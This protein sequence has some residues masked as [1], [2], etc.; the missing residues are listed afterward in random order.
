MIGEVKANQSHGVRVVKEFDLRSTIERCT[1]S[2]PV[3][4]IRFALGSS[5]TIL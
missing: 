1:G 5:H 2:S 4:D 3:R